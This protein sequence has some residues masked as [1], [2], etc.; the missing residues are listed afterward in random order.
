MYLPNTRC[1]Y[2]Q[3]KFNLKGEK[4]PN[5]YFEGILDPLG[6]LVL[7]GYDTTIIELKYF[8]DNISDHTQ[9]VVSDNGFDI[10]QYLSNND[11]MSDGIK[12]SLLDSLE[13]GRNGLILNLIDKLPEDEY[14]K[15]YNKFLQHF[16]EECERY[17]SEHEEDDDYDDYDDYDEE[18]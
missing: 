10:F 4:E 12:E 9:E 8:F 3:I 5:K 11:N 18:D 7:A 2:N 6:K 17:D 16:E 15:N 14:K 1:P 13:N